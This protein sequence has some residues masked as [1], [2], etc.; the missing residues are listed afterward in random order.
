MGHETGKQGGDVCQ[1]SV[2]PTGTGGYRRDARVQYPTC[3]GFQQRGFSYWTRLQTVSRNNI[4]H[5]E[6]TVCLPRRNDRTGC[7]PNVANSWRHRMRDF[8][9]DNNSKQRRRRT[10]DQVRS[11][12]KRET[13]RANRCPVTSKRERFVQDKQKTD[14]SMN[15]EAT[16]DGPSD[17]SC[18]QGQDN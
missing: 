4:S 1:N 3:Q 12:S 7:L 14:T 5:P 16:P 2:Q 13:I 6:D 17:K 10:G 9:Q 15:T 11:T 8:A 18:T